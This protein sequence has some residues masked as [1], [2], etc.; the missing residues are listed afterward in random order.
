MAFPLE[1]LISHPLKKRVYPT[2]SI[3]SCNFETWLA[4][5]EGMNAR[6]ISLLATT[7]LSQTILNADEKPNVLVVLFDDIGYGEAGCYNPE[8]DFTTP[9][10]DKLATQGMRFTDAHSCA[11]NCTPTRYGLITGQYPHRIG[12][13]GVLN[14]FSPPLI[15][16]T[17]I[18]IASF[19]KQ[20]GYNTACIGKWHLGMKWQMEKQEAKQKAAELNIGDKMTG[21]PNAIGFDY[22]YGFTHA[23]NIGMIIEQDTVV[24]QV[25]AVENQPIMVE[26]AV[27]FINDQKKSEKPFFLYY[28][29]CPPHSPTVPAAEFV[30]KGGKEGKR[31][32][33]ADWIYQGDDMLGKLLQALEE[34]GQAENTIVFVTGDNGASKRVY[35]PLRAHKGSIYEGGHREPCVVKWPGKIKPAS[36]SEQI[37]C[38]TDIFATV[39]DILGKKL[40]DNVGEDSASYL[41]CLLGKDDGPFREASVQQSGHGSLAIRK[42]PWKLIC[43]GDGTQELY[44]LGKDIGESTN[45]L[46]KETA[47]AKELTELLNTF[48]KNGRSTPGA[49]QPTKVTLVATGV[50]GKG[51][52][53][54]KKQTNKK[55]GD[56]KEGDKKK[57]KKSEN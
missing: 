54:A 33:Y 56:K 32:N 2:N 41:S 7:L 4:N 52:N 17:R 28:P 37:V 16:P 43:M 42:G 51:N 45:L 22:F 44:H 11:S 57:K 53:D 38:A 8:G 50:R 40:P 19:L 14:T 31:S 25:K 35:A 15:P 48:L 6:L 55:E 47:K 36:V 21:G 1:N 3:V 18:T 13:F 24:K 30:N 12:Q 23:R 46:N 9:H 29:M 10:L 26:K 27:Q 39:A 34:T 49:P 5:T 20:N